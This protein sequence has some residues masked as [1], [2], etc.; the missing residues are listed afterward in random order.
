MTKL[1]VLSGKHAGACIDLN[2]QTYTLGASDELDIYI[3]D[4]DAQTVK[5]QVSESSAEVCWQTGGSE[6]HMPLDQSVLQDGIHRVP[7]KPFIP[8]RF[9]A[10]II[11]IGPGNAMWPADAD[12]L[13]ILFTPPL[14][15]AATAKPVA[16]ASR[17]GLLIMAAVVACVATGLLGGSLFAS[18]TPLVT[19]Q[20]PT[21]LVDRVRKAVIEAKAEHLTIQQYGPLIT[22]RGLLDTRKQLISLNEKID[23]LQAKGQISRQY[24]SAEDVA[25]MIRESLSS[26]GLEVTRVADSATFHIKGEAANP[27]K[28][29]AT[30][31]GL[32]SDM[33]EVGVTLTSEISAQKNAG[34]G[35][36][37]AVLVDEDGMSY[38]Q[39]HDGVKHLVAMAPAPV[40]LSAPSLLPAPPNQPTDVT[41]V[42]LSPK[43]VLPAPVARSVVPARSAVGSGVSGASGPFE[44]TMP[45]PGSTSLS[46]SVA[47]VHVPLGVSKRARSAS[48]AA[49]Q[50]LLKN[51]LAAPKPIGQLA[52]NNKN[53]SQW[54]TERTAKNS[55]QEQ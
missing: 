48:S 18:N 20:K 24:R 49:E 38:S 43:E 55:F 41:V 5:I 35:K 53:S 44:V 42:D 23:A 26:L 9:G 19:L 37:S 40:A 22:L 3:G 7:L 17:K 46:A 12:I 39:S 21:P 16:P 28:V 52:R 50:P 32:E 11:C 4:W 1:R 6:R 2:E 8:V 45:V 31:V 27:A 15:A 29:K 30:I 54:T 25:D 10:V 47:P 33:A 34:D 14:P 51:E 13:R 36:F